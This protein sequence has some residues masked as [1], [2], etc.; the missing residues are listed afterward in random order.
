MDGGGWWTMMMVKK[1]TITRPGADDFDCVAAPR[2]SKSDTRGA[3]PGRG[4]FT[5]N[6]ECR[7]AKV[8]WMHDGWETG[9]VVPGSSDHQLQLARNQLADT[10]LARDGDSDLAILRLSASLVLTTY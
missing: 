1:L 3:G 9:S 10:Q 4:R 8:G 2:P 5:A 7:R 6:S